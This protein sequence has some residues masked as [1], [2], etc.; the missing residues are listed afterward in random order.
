[1]AEARVRAAMAGDGLA[2]AW[3]QLEV[4]QTAFAGLLPAAVLETPA[5]ELAESWT[6]TFRSKD[7]AV[8][9][10]LEGEQ[11]VGF[12][13][14]TVTPDAPEVGEIRVL[15][16]RPAWA[17]R[18]HGGRLIASAAAAVSALGAQRGEWWIPETDL[19]SQRFATSIGW[20]M[21][22]GARVLD[23]GRGMITE[24][25]WTGT[26]DLRLGGAE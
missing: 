6:A 16:V 2:I 3:I 12:T 17:R 5:A 4:W 7:Q 23:T 1:M 19:A 11:L 9:V 26:L 15:Y 13:Q 14:A 22:G 25:R 24:R 8:L 10:A 20:E 21:P 18:G